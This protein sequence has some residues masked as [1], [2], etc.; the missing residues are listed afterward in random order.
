[1]FPGESRGFG[2]VEMPNKDEADKVI[3]AEQVA[4]MAALMEAMRTARLPLRL[5]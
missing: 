1:M 5:S 4:L 3:S 2:F